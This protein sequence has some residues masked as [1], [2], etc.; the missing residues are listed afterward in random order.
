[1]THGNDG[2][3][4]F[5]LDL[6]IQ[7]P[8]WLADPDTRPPRVPRS[9]RWVTPTTFIQTLVDMNNAMNV[10]PGEFDA[11]GHDYRGDLARFVRA[12]YGLPCSDEQCARIEAAL[13]R[14]EVSRE[15]LFAQETAGPVSDGAHG[16]SGAP[17]PS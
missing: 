12:V 16:E 15:A 8:D 14:R 4:R 10:V 3:G 6:L 7:K 9:Q 1:V 17:A 11:K 2:V 5:G 13:R